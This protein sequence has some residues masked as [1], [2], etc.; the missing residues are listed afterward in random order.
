[1][2]REEKRQKPGRFGVQL[3]I[4]IEGTRRGEPYGCIHHSDL[5]RLVRFSGLWG[6]ILR[7]MDIDQLVREA[8]SGIGACCWEKEVCSL[9]REHRAK[10]RTEKKIREDFQVKFQGTQIKEILNLQILGRQGASLQGWI[11]GG[12]TNS[13][14]VF[15]RSALELMCW[16]SDVPIKK[17]I[18]NGEDIRQLQMQE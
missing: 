2:L 18:I 7:I 16:L 3:L 6:L 17:K 9:P 4:C 15:F 13:K 1:M 11:R 5:K 12:R 10:G 8:D 14:Q